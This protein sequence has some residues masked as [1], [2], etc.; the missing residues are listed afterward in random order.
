MLSK[1]KLHE[2]EQIIADAKPIARVIPYWIITGGSR[3]LLWVIVLSMWLST[4]HHN[5]SIAS[6]GKSFL[7][8]GGT[9]LPTLII[10][11]V[12]LGILFLWFQSRAKA[13]DYCVTNQRCI[14]SYGTWTNNRSVV[15]LNRVSDVYTNQSFL[16]KIFGITSLYITDMGGSNDRSRNRGRLRM[17]G[18]DEAKA[19][20]ILDTISQRI[21]CS[22][23]P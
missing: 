22:S 1:M 20:E 10:F 16:E 2:G 17:Q 19:E 15:P 4:F 11:G 12:I 18:L 5:L 23:K 3:I 13:H 6:A 8:S 21:S 7:S 14:F 9:I